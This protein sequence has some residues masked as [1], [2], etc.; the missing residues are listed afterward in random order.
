MPVID[1][2]V[3]PVVPSF[4]EKVAKG[5]SSVSGDAVHQKIQRWNNVTVAASKAHVLGVG[6]ACH[7]RWTVKALCAFP[8]NPSKH[9]NMQEMRAFRTLLRRERAEIWSDCAAEAAHKQER[10]KTLAGA[11]GAKASISN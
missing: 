9:I 6:L 8:D 4:N 7:C 5:I 11:I 1:G 2:V 10:G 3:Q